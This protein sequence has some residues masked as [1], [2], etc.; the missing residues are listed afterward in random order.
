MG[1]DEHMIY[2]LQADV[3]LALAN[4]KR[5]QILNLL[6]NGELSVAE[7]T[8][9]MF[10]AKANLSQHLTILRQKGIILARREGTTVYYRI[11]TPKIIEACS[12]MRTVLMES[13][14]FRENLSRSMREIDTADSV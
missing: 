2:E 3:C 1:N 11:V 12:I 7:M 5:L 13:L 4:P 6:K 14:D 9:I 8:N 10:I